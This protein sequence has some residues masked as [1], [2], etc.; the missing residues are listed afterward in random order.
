MLDGALGVLIKSS[1]SWETTSDAFMRLDIEFARKSSDL[2]IAVSSLESVLRK[3]IGCLISGLEIISLS[4][5]LLRAKLL[6][7]L[8]RSHLALILRLKPPLVLALEAVKLTELS[9]WGPVWGL[10]VVLIDVVYHFGLG[11][12]ATMNFVIVSVDIGVKF[13]IAEGDVLHFRFVVFFLCVE[14]GFVLD[15]PNGRCV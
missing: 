9:L 13:D 5:R 7:L 2:A 3:C 1:V 11:A 10:H 8:L 14:H 4:K 15:I 12:L 6:S